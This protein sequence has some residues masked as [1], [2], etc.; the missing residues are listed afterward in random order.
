MNK[1]YFKPV[2]E[3]VDKANRIFANEKKRILKLLPFAD[4]QH[5][6]S[7]AIPNSLTKGDLDINIRVKKDKLVEARSVLEKNYMP[8]KLNVWSDESASFEDYNYE[9]HLRIQL[10]T[11]GTKYDDFISLRD[12]L[13]HN[14][15]FVESYNRLKRKHEG[16]SMKVYRREKSAFL[17]KIKKMP[18]RE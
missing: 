2:N 11:I 15:S 10:S 13:L 5:I 3:F 4:V 8:N 9:L 7:T 14:P 1:V 16:K 6:G 17:E 18:G 12:K